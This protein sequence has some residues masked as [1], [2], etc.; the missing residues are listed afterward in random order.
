[1]SDLPA[2]SVGSVSTILNGFAFPSSGFWGNDQGVPLVRIRDINS[3]ST[4]VNY[5][6]TFDKQYLLDDGDVLIGMDGDFN[7][8]RWAGGRA[9]LNQRVCKI[10]AD[11]ERIDQGFLFHSLQP[12]LDLIHR[13]TPQTTV[14]HLSTDA[15]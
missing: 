2:I 6:G 10:T 5:R 1:M 9:L 15:I 4:K 13:R 8:V 12:Q 7:A 14:R 11:E 3:R